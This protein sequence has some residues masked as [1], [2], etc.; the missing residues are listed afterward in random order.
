[1]KCGVGGKRV[2]GTDSQTPASEPEINPWLPGPE[3]VQLAPWDS[4]TLEGLPPACAE[5]KQ[6]RLW[7]NGRGEE[8]KVGARWGG[9]SG[10]WAWG[11]PCP[12]CL[13][14]AGGSAK[15][16]G[17]LQPWETPQLKEA[18]SRKPPS[19]PPRSFLPPLPAAAVPRNPGHPQC[20]ACAF[21]AGARRQALRKPC[22]VP[23]P[24]WA[25]SSA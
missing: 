17:N 12:F 6:E 13:C 24:Q 3:G 19:H 7:R 20:R 8:G 4:Q 2:I 25:A 14:S 16:W 18:R 11:E 15:G 10:R 21:R 9:R 23:C 22:L 5:L 1:M